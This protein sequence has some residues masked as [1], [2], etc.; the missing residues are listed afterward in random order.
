MIIKMDIKSKL[1]MLS[2]GITKKIIIII[3]WKDVSRYFESYRHQLK[4]LLHVKFMK[5]FNKS[6][7][8]PQ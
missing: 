2:L 8:K 6:S 7:L 3:F 5:F 4:M 1:D